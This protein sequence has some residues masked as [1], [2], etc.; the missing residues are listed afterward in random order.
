M[1]RPWTATSPSETLPRGIPWIPWALATILWAL[2]Y[3][4]LGVAV[5]LRVEAS[6][7]TAGEAVEIRLDPSSAP[8]ASVRGADLVARWRPSSVLETTEI[9][10]TFGADG[11]LPWTPRDSGLLRLEVVDASGGVVAQRDL[12]VRQRRVPPLG[13]AVLCLAG[14]VLPTGIGRGLKK[15]LG[16]SSNYS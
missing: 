7:V 10:G 2:P 1:K 6:E 15:Q 16:G 8:N 9:L 11:R 12:A 5:E 13:L 14:A 3:P 4:A